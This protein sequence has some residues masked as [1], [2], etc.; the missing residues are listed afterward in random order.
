V[1]AVAGLVL[2]GIL[3]FRNETRGERY[4][5]VRGVAEEF[6]V[7]LSSYDYRR[8][9]Q[10]LARVRSMGAGHFRYEYEQVLGG[11]E[12]RKA[13][14]DNQAVATARVVEGPFVAAA[15][16]NEARVFSV[17]E[18]RIQARSNPQPQG[19][20]VVVETILVRTAG[21]WKVDWVVLS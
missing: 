3:L 5:E 13:L 4:R 20:R 6:S 8:L 7:A 14:Q 15:D 11:D 19:R 17:L 9:D 16:K 2:G 1:L 18:Q 21:G 10:D 12:F